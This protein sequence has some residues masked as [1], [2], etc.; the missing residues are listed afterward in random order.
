M[1]GFF[2][3]KGEKGVFGGFVGDLVGE[4]GVKGD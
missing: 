2:G 1:V 3:V 4:L